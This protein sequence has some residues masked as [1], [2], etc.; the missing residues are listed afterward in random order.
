MLSAHM[1]RI[2]MCVPHRTLQVADK[3]PTAAGAP[4]GSIFGNLIGGFIASYAHWKWVF[5]TMGLFSAL[6]AA[7]A[8]FLIPSPKATLHAQGA[9][10]KT[11][12]D[13]VGGFLITTGLICLMFALTQGNVVGWKTPWISCLI[14]ASLILIAVFVLWQRH[15]ENAGRY[16]L[17]KVSMFRSSRFSGAMVIMAL[18]F[19]SFNNFLVYAT[20]FFQEYQGYDEI[21]TTLRFLPTGVMGVVTA[22]I[23]AKILHKVPTFLLLLFGNFSVSL[24]NLLFA[25]P[26]PPTTSYFVYGLPAMVFSVFG[27]D[28]TW[29]SL[30]LFTSTA[31][32]DEDQALGGALINAVG[33]FGRAIALA[34]ATAIQTA[35][36]A[37]ER[38]VDVENAGRMEE[39]E[40]A[41]LK[42]LRAADWFGFGLGLCSIAV[43]IVFFRGAGVVGKVGPA[44][45]R[46]RSG[47]E[48]GVMNEE[49][50]N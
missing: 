46:G 20:Y 1:V 2:C 26:I 29:P 47:G 15:L 8:F 35:V 27:A 3:H 43:V 30:T 23:V 9:H 18:F 17:M 25:A 14:V 21:Q 33:Q 34:V 22:I 41:S 7:V 16:P 36:M 49:D 42:G 39:W 13:W 37:S 4:L 45:E 24:A 10:A 6:I 11:L 32:P 50:S 44:L 40:E 38:G 28:T 31:L 48:E 12:I 19:G 5:V